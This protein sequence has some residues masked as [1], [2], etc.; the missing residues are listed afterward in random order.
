M[1]QNMAIEIDGVE[2]ITTAEATEFALSRGYDDVSPESV[3]NA[4]R[5][6]KIKGSKKL[7]DGRNAPWV[8]PVESFELWLKSRKPR[9]RPRSENED[10]S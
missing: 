6:G 1:I 8:I 2:F 10:V 7:W 5:Q 9:G 4:A 3:A